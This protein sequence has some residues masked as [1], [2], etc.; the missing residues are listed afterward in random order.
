MGD[1][2]GARATRGGDVNELSEGLGWIADPSHWGGPD[3]I[4][5]RLGQHLQVSI[6]ALAVAALIAIPVGLVV[7]HTRRGQVLAA[8]VANVGRAIPSLAIL[9][10]AFLIVVNLLPGSDL[11]FG[12]L[13]TFIALTLLAIPP[14]LVNTD[15]GIVQVDGD[16][17]E[18]ARG[19]GMTGGQVLRKLELPVATPLIM[20]GLRLAAVTVVATAT[21]SA[22]IGGGTLG[23]FIV[24]GYAQQDTPKLVAGALLVAGLAILTEAVFAVL[25]RITTPRTRS[26]GRGP[27]VAD[28]AIRART[29]AP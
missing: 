18:A 11:A 1:P 13:P 8:Q 25:V 7:G 10:I 4:W 29:G 6:A 20:T 19:M 5:T 28:H 3:G 17:V 24:D 21:L 14:I 23:R 27:S 16:T 15:V 9:S 2:L 12:P 26:R 22:L